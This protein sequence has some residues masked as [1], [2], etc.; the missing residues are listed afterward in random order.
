MD[1]WH[2][3]N[4][5]P[6]NR[7]KSLYELQDSPAEHFQHVKIPWLLVNRHVAILQPFVSVVWA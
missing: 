4:L 5:N 7:F 2:V 6:V 3:G 1:R